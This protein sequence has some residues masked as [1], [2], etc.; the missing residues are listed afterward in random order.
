MASEIQDA[1][2]SN[3]NTE[4]RTRTEMTQEGDCPGSDTTVN[5]PDVL[6]KGSSLKTGA[7]PPGRLPGK[8]VNWKTIMAH[9]LNLSPAAA[10]S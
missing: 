8:M 3:A 4:G 9:L 5:N 2:R 6:Y 1:R 10:N 7:D